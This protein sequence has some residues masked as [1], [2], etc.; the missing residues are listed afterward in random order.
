[1]RHHIVRMEVLE[2]ALSTTATLSMRQSSPQRVLSVE[3]TGVGVGHVEFLWFMVGKPTGKP[4]KTDV[5]TKKHA[6]FMAFHQEE[7]RMEKNT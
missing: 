4:S 6:G 2:S 5:F 1:M 3:G 7:W